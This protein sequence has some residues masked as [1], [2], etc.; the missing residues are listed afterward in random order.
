MSTPTAPTL[1]LRVAPENPDHHLWDNHGTW[2]CHFTVHLPDYTSQ[3]RR[4]SL[5]TR[6]RGE[7]RRRRDALLASLQARPRSTGGQAGRPGDRHP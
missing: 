3:R 5:R 2:W 7:A 6:D 1:A 4:V